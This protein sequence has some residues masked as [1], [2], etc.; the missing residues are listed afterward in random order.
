MDAGA[1][2]GREVTPV[3]ARAHA[4]V[5]DLDVP[6]L[7]DGDEHHLLRVLRLAPGDDVTA[8]DGAGRWRACRLA[9]GRALEIAGPIVAEPRPAPPITVAFALVKG[10][11]PELVVQKLTELGA[12]RIVPFVAERS[13]V[14]WDA[15]KAG[16]QAE[17]LAAIARAAAMQC[18]RT[19]LPEV[20]PLATF[21]E[22]A[23]LPGAAMADRGGGAPRLT[24][25]VVLV[26][27][28][29]GWSPAERSSTIPR[30]RLGPHVLRA[31]TAS[32]TSCVILSALRDEV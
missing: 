1:G 16:R 20:A 29:G 4:F 27:P 5:P 30:V 18:R 26:G 21:A 31:E 22:V 12:D 7:D 8:G 6:A 14:R 10:E 13:V 9:G 24:L 23:A 32:I 19:W 11:R 28:E 3:S 2:G 15:A 25:P 17:R